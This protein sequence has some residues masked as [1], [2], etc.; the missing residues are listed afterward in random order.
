M[1]MGSVDLMVCQGSSRSI[2]YCQ[3]GR[4]E[5]MR[6]S[7]GLINSEVSW[8]QPEELTE[9]MSSK[10]VSLDQQVQLTEEE[11]QNDILMIG[12]IS[13]F[14]P[15]AQEEAENCVADG[16]TTEQ[17]TVTTGDDCQKERNWSRH[18]RL[19]KQ[20][21]KENEHSEEWLNDFSQEAEKL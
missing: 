2:P 6:L 11:D 3:V 5:Q 14:L 13:I 20:D 4:D 16:A 8:N 17:G 10:E 21:E 1:K 15:F 12:G 19:P 18:L 9:Q 7:E